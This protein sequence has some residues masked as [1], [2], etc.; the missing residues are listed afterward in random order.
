METTI[1]QLMLNESLP[2]DMRDYNRVLDKKGIKKLLAEVAEKHPERYRDVVQRLSN[3]GR[4]ASFTTGGYS[5]GLKH[6]RTS[7]AAKK[8]RAQI[9]RELDSIYAKPMDDDA[10]DA[11]VLKT[12][13]KYQKTLGDDVFREAFESGNPLAMQTVSGARGNKTNLSSL[14]GADM[15]YTDHRDRVLPIPVTRSYSM[16]LRPHEYFAGAFGARKGIIDLKTATAD[17]GFLA[18]LLV[19]AAHRLLVSKA[20]SEDPYDETNPRGY[21]SDITDPDN[22]GALL[23]HPVGR[24]KRNTMLTPKVLK[25]LQSEGHDTILVRSP[26]VGGPKDGGVYANDVGRRERGRVA[27]TGDYV[28]IAAVQALSEPITQS[29]I[30]SKHSGGIAGASAGAI[31]GFKSIEQ[32]IQVPKT[33]KG[34]AAHAQMDGTVQSVR[35]A[36]QGGHF[37]TIGGEEHY[38]GQGYPLR[39]KKG[40]T[41]EAGDVISDGIP[42]PA[43]IVRHK[44][45]GEGRRYFVDTFRDTLKNSNVNGHRRN[46]ELLARGLINHVRM[47]DEYDDYLPDDVVPYQFIEA[48]WKP[49]P[50]HQVVS[51]RQSVGKYLERPVLHYSVGTKIRPSVA[52][53]LE[54]YK[55]GQVYTHHDPAPF[56]PE[57][58]R[59]MTNAAHDPDFMTKMLGSYQKDSV[60]EAARRG[61]TS[62][63]SGTSYPASLARGSGFGQVGKTKGWSPSAPG[64]DLNNR[65]IL[66]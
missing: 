50:G 64:M 55:V 5:F 14:I 41:V 34:G 49:R 62:D 2:E 18:K 28:G 20:D 24:F 21:P 4:D 65:N 9:E 17:A 7:L 53:Q 59:G 1:G 35:E 47:R 60:L 26:L 13:N 19:Q 16:G 37:V 39:V 33:F 6:L 66:E 25:E 56:E 57:M 30:S 27:P 48:N 58:I 36:P 11:A 8:M 42:N 54:K 23:A 40:D 10:R 45:V 31:S 51:P 12:V 15:L 46:I 43:E 32:L 52:K 29:Q 61:G 63:A 3:V 22:A 44:G 38:V